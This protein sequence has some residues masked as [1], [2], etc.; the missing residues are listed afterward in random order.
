MKAII[1]RSML[2]LACSTLAIA[3]LAE[4][5]ASPAPTATGAETSSPLAGFERLVGGEWHIGP[6][7]HVFEWGVGKNTVLARSYDGDGNL[8]SEARWFFHPGEQVIRGYSIGASGNFFA[9]MT[10]RFEG[11][12]LINELKTIGADG[13]TAHYTGRWLFTDDD[14]Y[15]WTLFAETADGPQQTMQATATRKQAAGAAP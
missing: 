7:R 3:A 12:T 4:E 9:E 8:A 14:H 15:D 5:P 10:T 6:L 1:R 11:D 2:V 13:A